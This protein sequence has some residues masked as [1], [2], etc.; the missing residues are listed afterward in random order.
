MQKLPKFAVWNKEI[1]FDDTVFL[2]Q[3]GTYAV[4]CYDDGGKNGLW[5]H[6]VTDEYPDL[7]IIFEEEQ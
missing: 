7:E 3:D 5:E 6:D 1:D 2:R 4:F